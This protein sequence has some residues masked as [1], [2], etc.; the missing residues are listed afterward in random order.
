MRRISADRG[1]TFGLKYE[2]RQVFRDRVFR[3]RGAR[4]NFARDNEQAVISTQLRFGMGDCHT[5]G[6]RSL[7]NGNRVASVWFRPPRNNFR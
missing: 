4:D 5:R 2:P 1:K 6:W 7:K 3:D